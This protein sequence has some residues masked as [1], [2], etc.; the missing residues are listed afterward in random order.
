VAGPKD[1]KRAVGDA[2][3]G[4]GEPGHFREDEVVSEDAVVDDETDPA[5][6]PEDRSPAGTGEPGHFREDEVVPLDDDYDPA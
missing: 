5:A 6:A 4:T 3:A 1:E 2:P